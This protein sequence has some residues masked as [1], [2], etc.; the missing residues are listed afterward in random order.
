[1]VLFE[2]VITVS[3]HGDVLFMLLGS[4]PSFGLYLFMVYPD[5]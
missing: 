5:D 1:V 4:N 3:E 2:C